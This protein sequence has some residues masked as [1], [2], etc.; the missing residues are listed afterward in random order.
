[1]TAGELDP[2]GPEILDGHLYDYPAY[3]DLIFGSDAPPKGPFFEDCFRQMAQRPVERIFEPA[4]GTGRLLYRLARRGYSVAGNDLNR[5]R[6]PTASEIR[7]G[8]WDPP[9]VLGDMSDFRLRRRPMRP[10]TRSTVSRDLDNETPHAITSVWGAPL[11]RG[12][13]YLL[14]LHLTPTAAA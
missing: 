10:S 5:T 4:C 6:S 14:G 7:T 3:Y 8:R 9:A 13:L 1:M 11:A 12:G 2:V